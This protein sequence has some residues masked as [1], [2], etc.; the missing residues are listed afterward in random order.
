MLN[1]GEKVSGSREGGECKQY[2]RRVDFTARFPGT[3]F[4]IPVLGFPANSRQSPSDV[5]SSEMLLSPAAAIKRSALGRSTATTL[6]IGLHSASTV[7]KEEIYL[8]DKILV[9]G[10]LHF[11]AS[12]SFYFL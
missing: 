7:I 2:L 8:A 6:Q 1:W 3:L 4:L 12:A 5:T 9:Y 11:T 10:G